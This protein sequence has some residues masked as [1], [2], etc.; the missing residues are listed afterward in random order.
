MVYQRL[1]LDDDI[2]YIESSK[3]NIRG[4]KN[5]KTKTYKKNNKKKIIDKRKIGKGSPFSNQISIGFICKNKDHSHKNPIC[6]K[7]FKN[8]KIHMTGCKN[9]EEVEHFYN[10]L[11]NKI[12]NIKTEY[13]INDRII[14]IYP[15][16]NI[17]EYDQNNVLVDMVNGTFKTNFKIDLSKFFK[18]I[19]EVYAEE[20][21]FIN[22]QKKTQLIC[23]L[24][25]YKITNI[26]KRIEKQPSIFIYNSGSI[27][28]IAVSLEILHKS[29]ELISSFIDK[30][31]DEIIEID[32]T[33]FTQD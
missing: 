31:H 17:K 13:T 6:I 28:V 2:K 5:K 24:K 1:K 10:K 20:D 22:Y 29:Y 23:Y 18:K 7:L 11:Y 30:Y 32:I 19:K 3:T 25:K 8:G 12:N 15:I 21:I 16:K 9:L 33:Y 14:N 26:E 27:N 4:V